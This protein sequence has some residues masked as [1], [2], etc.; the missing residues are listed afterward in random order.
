MAFTMFDDAAYEVQKKMK[1]ES[2]QAFWEKVKSL[3]FRKTTGYLILF[4]FFSSITA[5]S[6]SPLIG[7]FLRTCTILRST[8][9][10][11]RLN[12]L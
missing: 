12:P 3:S 7:S 1:R 9:H 8:I 6:Q 11:I 2:R 10:G 5:L 4:G